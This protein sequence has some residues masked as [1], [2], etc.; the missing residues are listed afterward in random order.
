MQSTI[1][2]PD[3]PDQLNALDC[4]GLADNLF[5]DIGLRILTAYSQTT[6]NDA[7][8]ASGQYAY[9]AAVRS[10]R[11]ILK[12]KGWEPLREANVELITNAELKVNILVSSADKFTGMENREPSNKNP[13]GSQTRNIV[14]KNPKQP[15]LFPDMNVVAQ[16]KLEP[17]PTWFLFYHVDVKNDEMRMELSLPNSYDLERRKIHGL[18][19][20]IILSPIEFD[21]YEI[22]IEEEFAPE[23]EFEIKRKGNE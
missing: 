21:G 18:V 11:D 1:M 8:G 12:R 7:A 5:H 16:L 22:E 13:K 6:P 23:F 3:T 2:L 20:R 15:Y 4:L 14:S 19:E 10:I 9:L 17:T